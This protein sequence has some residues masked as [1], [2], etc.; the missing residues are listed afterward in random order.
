MKGMRGE[1]EVTTS[2]VAKIAR[3]YTKCP[4][5]PLDMIEMI[6]TH[7]RQPSPAECM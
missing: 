3:Y 1:D 6:P 7:H 4:Y 2:D 5:S